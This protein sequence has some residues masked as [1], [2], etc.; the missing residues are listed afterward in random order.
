MFTLSLLFVKFKVLTSNSWHMTAEQDISKRN[1][2]FL[3]K[4]TNTLPGEISS[5]PNSNK[6]F[7]S[8]KN[9]GIPLYL[10]LYQIILE[11]D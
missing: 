10:S 8:T 1:I 3:K 7:S 9:P 11:K 4:L 5:S 6:E 2:I